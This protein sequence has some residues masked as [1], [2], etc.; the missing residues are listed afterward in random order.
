MKKL[1]VVLLVLLTVF[2]AFA[3]GQGESASSKSVDDNP[4]AEYVELIMYSSGSSGKDTA[5]VMEKFNALLK[6]K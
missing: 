6:E 5:K 3:K 1:L 2:S 4:F